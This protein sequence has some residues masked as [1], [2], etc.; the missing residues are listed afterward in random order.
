V[1]IEDAVHGPRRADVVPLV[2]RRRV[3]LA[4]AFDLSDGVAD[5]REH[6]RSSTRKEACSNWARQR[7]PPPPR[8]TI[9]AYP[10]RR[11]CSSR[12]TWWAPASR[13]VALLRPRPLACSSRRTWWAPARAGTPGSRGPAASPTSTAAPRA[14]AA[15]AR[16]LQSVANVLSFAVVLGRFR[17]RLQIAGESVD[18]LRSGNEELGRPSAAADG[19]TFATGS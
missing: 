8:R 16:P 19:M 5:L 9:A 2:E 3:D 11:P 17:S 14:A 6:R 10:A 12:R 15:R 1:R 7:S 4:D 13:R 18:S